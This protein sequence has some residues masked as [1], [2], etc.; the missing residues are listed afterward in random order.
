MHIHTYLGRGNAG[1]ADYNGSAPDD[2]D[3]IAPGGE[4][5]PLNEAYIPP[6]PSLDPAPKQP[7][8]PTDTATEGTKEE[9]GG[10]EDAGAPSAL[11]KGALEKGGEAGGTRTSPG[12]TAEEV[13]KWKAE[14][15]GN[16][17]QTATAL[18]AGKP[19]GQEK[20]LEVKRMDPHLQLM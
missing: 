10:K 2:R 20:E 13:E 14:N 18:V 1:T 19:A 12:P 5:A 17:T 4:T 16:G 8:G 3:R 11:D 15:G 6:P 7:M 9:L